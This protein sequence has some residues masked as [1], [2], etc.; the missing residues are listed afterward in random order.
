ML[1]QTK[2]F[3]PSLFVSEFETVKAKAA[4]LAH[5]LAESLSADESIRSLD[6]EQMEE[7]LHETVSREGSIQL[8]AVTNLEGQRISQVYTQRGEKALFRNLLTKDFRKHEWFTQV[9]ETREAY[10]SDLFF[11]KYTGRLI[12]TS[13]HPLFDDQG[14]MFGVLDVDF[15]FD[16]LVKIIT[17]IPAEILEI[18]T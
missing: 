12:L 10:D 17:P 1:A 13:A 5:D 3:V 8:I 18:P 15:V 9:I 11:S 7:K 16:E 6:H 14:K 4:S 2:R